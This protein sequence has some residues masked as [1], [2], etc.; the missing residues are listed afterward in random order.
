MH[1]TQRS[2]L[3]SEK[4]RGLRAE[5]VQEFI[6]LQLAF[7]W[8]LKHRLRKTDAQ[9]DLQRLL[10]PRGTPRCSAIRCRPRKSCYAWANGAAA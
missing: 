1:I 10:P 4:L 8:S 3:R 6:G 2:L 9:A 5:Q 7:S